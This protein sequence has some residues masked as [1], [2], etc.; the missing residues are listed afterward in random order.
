[1]ERLLIFPSP[2]TPGLPSGTPSSGVSCAGSCSSE[3]LICCVTLNHLWMMVRMKTRN[4]PLPHRHPGSWR[5]LLV[6]GTELG[7]AVCFTTRTICAHPLGA[8]GHSSTPVLHPLAQVL[9]TI[10]HPLTKVITLMGAGR[11]TAEER[12]L[13]GKGRKA[14]GSS[15]T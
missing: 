5:L 1:M 9:R 10:E 11:K 6:A 2:C 4:L 15:R 8:P 12:A 13:L 3:A 7:A 14:Q